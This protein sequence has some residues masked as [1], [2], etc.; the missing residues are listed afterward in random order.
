MTVKD[1]ILTVTLMLGAGLCARLIADLLHLPHMLVLLGVGILLGSSVSDTI[2]VPLDSMGA[3]LVLTLGVSFILFHGGLQLSVGILRKVAVGLLLL[4]VPGV[5]LT[6]LVTGSV[7]ALLFGL[8]LSSG[9]LI[10]AAL[11]PTDPA[12]LVPLF[13]R[14]RVR[15]KL[16]QT[17]IAESALNDPT[18]AVLA[19]AFAG[20]VLSGHASV[21]APMVDFV[22]DLAISTAMGVVFGIV[23]SAAVSSRRAGIWRESC[24]IAVLAVVA[25][26]FFSIDSAGG[27]G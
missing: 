1:V 7:A 22:K 26:S 8:P 17:I 21:T 16:S 18:G 25:G 12:I 27:S 10:G 5:V 9:L 4:V 20:V 19:L 3:Q 13:E 2:D 14:L 15:P 11:S 24:S 23:L 6:A